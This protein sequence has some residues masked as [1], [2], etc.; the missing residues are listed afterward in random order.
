[1]KKNFLNITTQNWGL[2]LLLTFI[3]I[4]RIPLLYQPI[5]DIDESVFGEFANKILQGKTPYLDAIDNK[6]V[7]NYYF[8]A[9]IYAIFGKNSLIAMHFFT[10]LLVLLTGVFIYFAS[11]KAKN[12]TTAMASLASFILLAHAYEPKNISS[13]GETF[14]NIFFALV[15]VLY[16]YYRQQGKF[17]PYLFLLMGFLMGI[18]IMIRYQVGLFLIPFLLEPL[19]FYFSLSKPKPKGYFVK[20]FQNLVLLGLSSILPFA[21]ILFISYQQGFLEKHL[22]WSLTY[23]FKYIASGSDTVPLSQLFLRMGLFILSSFFAWLFLFYKLKE[24]KKALFKKEHIKT[25]FLVL[26]VLFG[27]Y[28]VSIGKR[29]FGHYFLHLI[30][31]LALLSGFGIKTYLLKPHKKLKLR[32]ILLLFLIPSFIF[33]LPRISL[34]FTY[35]LLNNPYGKAD[36]AYQKAGQYIQ[37][38][39]FDNDTVFVWGFGTPL[40]YYANREHFSPYLTAD[41]ISGRVFGTPDDLLVQTPIMEGVKEDFLKQFEENPPLYFVDTAPADFYGYKRFPLKNYPKI[42]N[43]LNKNYQKETTFYSMDI[44]RRKN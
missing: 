17:Q 32:G 44:Y 21:I 15:F 23:N 13:N 18:A 9:F 5:F 39:S 29:A 36:F 41:F 2:F 8:F 38:N 20:E 6:P 16:F 26:W 27:L 31:P 37:K 30:V 12:W 24:V 28:I 1:M 43:L 3:F 7:L 42:L 10:T 25:L 11:L 40:A 35:T 4:L 14:C 34:N 33:T 19:F 22:F